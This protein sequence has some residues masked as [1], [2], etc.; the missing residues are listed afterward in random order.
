MVA[1][2]RRWRRL[3]QPAGTPEPQPQTELEKLLSPNRQAAD[4]PVSLPAQFFKA[5][6]DHWH[7]IAKM[8]SGQSYYFQE[9]D[10]DDDLQWAHLG[11]VN[12]VKPSPDPAPEGQSFFWGRGVAVR[13]SDIESIADCD[14]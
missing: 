9:L 14:S 7:Y 10:Y 6:Q 2:F 1:F 11:H 12:G 5:A 3:P 8:R 13:I 4:K